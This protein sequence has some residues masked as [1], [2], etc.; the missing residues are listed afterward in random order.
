[1]NGQRR[2]VGY[3]PSSFRLHPLVPGQAVTERGRYR[4]SLHVGPGWVRWGT[5]PFRLIRTRDE[6]CCGQTGSC[7]RIRSLVGNVRVQAEKSLKSLRFAGGRPEPCEPSGGRK[8]AGRTSLK[9]SPSA[10]GG[11]ER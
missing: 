10:W 2:T 1:M 7:T 11:G 9:G 3:H 6:F 8:Q 5:T 4:G